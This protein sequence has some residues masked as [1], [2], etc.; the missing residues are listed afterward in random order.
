MKIRFYIAGIAMVTASSFA[1]SAA[2][3]P[4]T[5]VAGEPIN[6][7]EMNNNFSDLKQQ[8]INLET[9]VDAIPAP[10]SG[11]G[12]GSNI[13]VFEGFSNDMVESNVGFLGMNN[14]CNATYSGSRMCTVKEAVGN[15]N[16]TSL[17]AVNAFVNSDSSD[18]A[19]WR[20]NTC[21]GW[22]SNL[23]GTSYYVNW[24]LQVGIVSCAIPKY[25]ACCSVQ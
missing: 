1:A 4:H 17:P 24:F 12:S 3:V 13:V 16:V 15:T 21:G 6:A 22:S 10:I 11:G 18:L 14:A 9:K 19:V 20:N 5:F 23:S 25:V 8:I 7:T 2:S